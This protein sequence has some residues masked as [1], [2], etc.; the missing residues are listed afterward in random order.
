MSGSLI[1]EDS[2]VKLA[3]VIR[4]KNGLSRT[5][6]PGEMADAILALETEAVSD[7]DPISIE[8]LHDTLEDFIDTEEKIRTIGI[9]SFYRS[10][11]IRSINVPRCTSIGAYAFYQVNT[12]ESVQI[13]SCTSIG[14]AAF[15]DCVNLVSL[16]SGV[17]ISSLGN[18]AF[19]NCIGLTEYSTISGGTINGSAF[20]GCSNIVT[21]S[22]GSYC[23]FY[24]AFQ[25]CTS[26]ESITLKNTGTPCHI[27]GNA[28]SYFAQTKIPTTG[29]IY[30]PQ[31]MMDKYLEDERWATLESRF[32][33]IP[34]PPT[35]PEEEGGA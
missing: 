25:G 9:Y 19:A 24:S 10:E 15:A 26:L 2:I 28:D 13:P 7:V 8:I 16:G 27:E 14:N 4:Q 34:P 22:F 33:I 5:Y 23:N 35:P 32:D 20:A 6:K 12:L 11:T 21:M 3:N 30:V 31:S 1:I 29:H 18:S 17:K